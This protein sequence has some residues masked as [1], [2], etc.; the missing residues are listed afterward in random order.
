MDFQLFAKNQVF[1]PVLELLCTNGQQ[2]TPTAR[3]SPPRLCRSCLGLFAH[4][5]HSPGLVQ[6]FESAPFYSVYA[7]CAP[8]IGA[9][10][11]LSP[12]LRQNNRRKTGQGLHLES[13]TQDEG[14]WG[15]VGRSWDRGSLYG[16]SPDG[17]NHTS[18]RKAPAKR[19]LPA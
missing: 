3:I 5:Y 10:K 14:P 16:M 12:L 18:Q 9:D 17:G 19:M 2:L 4:L 13:V 7:H 6:A 15:R 1:L 8:G 11:I